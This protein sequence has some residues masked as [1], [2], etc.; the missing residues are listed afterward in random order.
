MREREQKETKPNNI[1][2]IPI[3]HENS[4]IAN[5]IFNNN[6][7]KI[8]AVNAAGL[9]VYGYAY[10]EMMRLSVTDLMFEYDPSSYPT[11]QNNNSA[12]SYKCTGAQLHRTKKGEIIQINMYLYAVGIEGVAATCAVLFKEPITRTEKVKIPEPTHPAGE[13]IHL[14]QE[15]ILADFV[16]F[17]WVKKPNERKLEYIDNACLQV[18]GYTPAEFMDENSDLFF[19]C[20]VPEGFAVVQE[21]ITDL[22][23]HPEK[24]VIQQFKIRK[25]NG[26]IVHTYNEMRIHQAHYSDEILIYGI[27]REAT[28]EHNNSISLNEK[29]EELETLLD[30][31]LDAY[32]RLD[33]NWCFTYVNK[34][35]LNLTKKR[36][37][38]LIG[39][40]IW[41]V[42]PYLIDLKMYKQYFKA[43]T[44]KVAVS[45]EEYSPVLD[46]H[47]MI[48]AYPNTNGLTVC[49]TNITEQKK[50]QER[51]AAN[52]KNLHALIDS[53]NDF[54]FSVDTELKLISINKPFKD[55]KYQ[56]TGIVPEQGNPVVPF[57]YGN[58]VVSRL[59]EMR[60][61]KA[62]ETGAYTKIIKIPTNTTA[63]YIE[64]K[65][66]PILEEHGKI[67]GV[68]CLAKDITE[69]M[70]L[71]QR[72]IEDDSNLKAIVNN[73]ED[74]IWLLDTSFQVVFANLPF[75][76]LIKKIATTIPDFESSFSLAVLGE[77]VFGNMAPKLEEALRGE[78]V[79]TEEEI[80]IDDNMKLFESHYNPVLNP[81]NRIIGISC[82]LRDI[83][84]NKKHINFINTQNKVLREIAWILSHQIRAKEAT[85]LGLAQLYNAE[86]QSDKLNDFV[87]NGFKDCAEGLDDII[88]EVN[89]K[90]KTPEVEELA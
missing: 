24:K 58:E 29:A 42:F 79:V 22:L 46:A 78:R 71:Q 67:A 82:F 87:F 69:Q 73:T 80:L 35:Y 65:F 16:R 11:I 49:L 51:I 50:L 2:G 44:E 4:P 10:E 12:G 70:T 84:E 60:L 75:K 81:D 32:M 45:F 20:V 17:A 15:R 89:D 19:Q 54:L 66:N 83:T 37:E 36:K 62:M 48:R 33:T 5:L 26:R 41:E 25:K 9:D 8:L 14:N 43:L 57:G 90:I 63:K 74:M 61:K 23:H 28:E 21:A 34:E 27:T 31:I 85:I 39:K 53:T 52:E 55:F 56:L 59:W 64:A 72:I 40:S 3:L 76:K 6:T 77:T 88:R 1:F 86:D 7:L 47:L 13:L 30:T 38:E 68:S 18:T